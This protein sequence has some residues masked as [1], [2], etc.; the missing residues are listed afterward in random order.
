MLLT[1]NGTAI[2]SALFKSLPYDL[3]KDFEHI[4]SLASFDLAM[5]T[6]PDSG[7]NFFADVLVYARANPGK[8]SIGTSRVGSTQ[9]LVAEMFTS[10][11][12]IDLVSVPYRTTS[13]MGLALR[14]KAVSVAFEIILPVLGQIRGKTIIP[15]AITASGRFTGLSDVPTLSESGVPNFEASSWVGVSVPALTFPAIIGRLAGE[16]RLAV[17]SPEVQ[18]SFQAQEVVGKASTPE[19]MT[20]RIDEDMFKWKTV[21]EKTGIPRQ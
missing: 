4:S 18:R 21:I 13:D 8:L 17:A 20:L 6:S 11:A 5:I 12:G 19:E 1:G 15:L 7:F 16:I 10:M 9:H 14:A 2:S 3:N